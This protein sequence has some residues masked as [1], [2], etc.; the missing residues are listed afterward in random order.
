MYYYFITN[1]QEVFEREE[2]VDVTVYPQ[3]KELTPDQVE[4]HLAHPE[5]KRYEIEHKD[6]PIPPVPPVP[7]FDL[8]EY[9]A[10]ARKKVSAVSLAH[11][12]EIIPSYQVTNAQVT[13]NAIATG[14]Q[15]TIYT[16]S[17]AEAILFEAN[18]IGK[19]CREEYYRVE[20]LI[21][22]ATDKDGVDAAVAD[23]RFDIIMVNQTW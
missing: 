19:L 15:D 1:R 14:I 2:A 5:A 13:I 8:D 11:I 22:A 12:A 9:K 21:N 23:A 20:G 4:Y 7:P 3:Y 17:K 10:E 18:R 16:Q 6:D